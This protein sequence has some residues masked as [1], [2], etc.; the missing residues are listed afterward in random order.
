[1]D[2]LFM[3]LLAGNSL[4]TNSIVVASLIIT[5]C[6][7]PSLAIAGGNSLIALGQI[8]QETQFPT[9]PLFLRI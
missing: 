8:K 7:W 4:T 1:M 6:H 2:L 5:G 3:S 9:V